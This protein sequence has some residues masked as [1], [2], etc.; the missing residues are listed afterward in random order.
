[1]SLVPGCNRPLDRIPRWMVDQFRH[2]DESMFEMASGTVKDASAGAY[3]VV[4]EF[5]DFFLPQQANPNLLL[6]RVSSMDL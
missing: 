3:D 6:S 2:T 5:L 1:M 4:A